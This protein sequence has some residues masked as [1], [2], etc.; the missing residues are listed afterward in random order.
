MPR[1]SGISKHDE[2]PQL[3]QTVVKGVMVDISVVS[4]H[5]VLFNPDYIAPAPTIECNHR[6]VAW[7]RWIMRDAEH[8]RES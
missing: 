1:C 8:R 3:E 7:D 6:L 5:Q 2:H 4:T